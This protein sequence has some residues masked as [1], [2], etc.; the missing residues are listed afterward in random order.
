MTLYSINPTTEQEIARFDPDSDQQVEAKIASAAAAFRSWRRTSFEERSALMRRAADHI[1]ANRERLSRT[2][3]DEMGKPIVQAR[4]EV[5]RFAGRCDYFAEHTAAMLSPEHVPIPGLDS[6]VRFE[7]LGVALG[8][9][10]WNFPFGQASRWAVPALMAGNTALLKH[11][12]NV[13][14]S[15]LAI[16]EVFDSAGFPPGVFTP[17]FVP[18]DR[19]ATVIADPRVASVSLTGSAAAGERV[20]AAAGQ[21]LKKVVLELGGS[22]PFIVL[23]DADIRIAAEAATRGRFGNNSGQACTASK[24]FVVV[25]D[26]VEA[27]T[28]CFVE[29]T[30]KLRTGNPLE[31]TTDVGPLARSDSLAELTGQYDATVAAGAWVAYR[32]K[33][34]P[35]PGYFFP[36]TVLAGVSPDMVAAQE[37]TF[38]PLA[39]I[40][41]VRDTEAAISVANHSP[42]GLGCSIWT[43]DVERAS[44]LAGDLEAGMVAINS[45][46]VADPR[47]PFGGVKRSGYGREMSIHGVRE[48]TNIKAVNV[49]SADSPRFSR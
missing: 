9:M 31:E 23:A 37:E 40:V 33:L 26:V 46:V 15:A 49:G 44:A 11:A 24:R 12:S 10:P 13:T 14:L 28:E 8:I 6:W 47:L 5:D 17:L 39:A 22:D 43:A 38:G 20:G 30:R 25:A 42:Y 29:E 45:L 3:V 34:E 36:P 27:F 1:R 2:L 32:A 21:A 7:P 18:S 48:L 35:G 4:R 19:I 41:S 16:Q